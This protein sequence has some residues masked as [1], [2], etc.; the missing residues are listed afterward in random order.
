MHDYLGKRA[1]DE[2]VCKLNQEKYIAKTDWKIR[3]RYFT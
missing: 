1:L 2:K 3:V